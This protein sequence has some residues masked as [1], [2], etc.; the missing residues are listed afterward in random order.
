M[1]TSVWAAYIRSRIEWHVTE[2]VS[3]RTKALYVQ[4][5]A[6]MLAYYELAFDAISFNQVKRLQKIVVTTDD[7]ELRID[8]HR[9]LGYSDGRQIVSEFFDDWRFE[10]IVPSMEIGHHMM[11]EYY[12]DLD[13]AH[14]WKLMN[15]LIHYAANVGTEPYVTTRYYTLYAPFDWKHIPLGSRYE[16]LKRLITLNSYRVP[17][18]LYNM[19][20]LINERRRIVEEIQQGNAPKGT[21]QYWSEGDQWSTKTGKRI[22]DFVQHYHHEHR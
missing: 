17:I 16:Q 18:F 3:E 13:F 22:L 20:Y 12:E 7:E 9:V 14:Y 10:S 4:M 11:G 8:G 21:N 1:E 19:Q 15:D 2:P 6:R 5:M